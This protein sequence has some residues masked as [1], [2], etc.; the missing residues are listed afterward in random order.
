MQT[1]AIE[2]EFWLLEGRIT[3]S[4][5]GEATVDAGFGDEWLRQLDSPELD[6]TAVSRSN[7]LATAIQFGLLDADPQIS[8]AL[9][10]FATLRRVVETSTLVVLL[11]PPI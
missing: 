4:D 1:L 10:R 7:S 11:V 3:L 5:T 8:T 9:A 2:I 6:A